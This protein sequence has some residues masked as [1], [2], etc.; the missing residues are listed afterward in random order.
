MSCDARFQRD[1][2]TSRSRVEFQVKSGSPWKNVNRFQE[3]RLSELPCLLCLTFVG[4]AFI[5]TVCPV[6]CT[7]VVCVGEWAQIQQMGGL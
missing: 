5:V 4:V 3:R 7:C 2:S 1:H 6:F